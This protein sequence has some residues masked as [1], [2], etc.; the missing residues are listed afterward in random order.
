MGIETAL[1]VTAVAAVVGAGATAYS[2][3]QQGEAARRANTR[4]KGIAN[5]ERERQTK[6]DALL[7]AQE[8]AQA[9]KTAGALRAT[10]G[11]RAG[12]RSLLGGSETGVANDNTSQNLAS[13]STLG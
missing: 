4:A 10:A 6:A 13:Q 11:A 5:T 8:G 1:I 9:E 2:A 7:K 3:Q 12:R